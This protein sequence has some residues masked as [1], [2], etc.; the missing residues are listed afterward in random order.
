M[1]PCVMEP[2]NTPKRAA[3]P[4]LSENRP[5]AHFSWGFSLP[6][7]AGRLILSSRTLRRWSALAIAISVVLLA[8]LVV[9][10]ILGTG[11]IV[12]LIWP[13]PDDWWLLLW[14]PLAALVFSLLFVAGGSTIPT[15]ATAPILDR[16]S[17]ETER[18]LGF[19]LPA[20]AG[21]AKL[22]RETVGASLKAGMRV[23]ILL[24]G[25]ALLLLL[26]L[27]PGAGP[28]IWTVGS[29]IWTIFWIAYEYVDIAANRH[30][31]RFME[32]VRAVRGH[33]FASVGLGSALYLM[34]LVPLLNVV[35]IPV[36]AVSATCF[37][38]ELR[39]SGGLPASRREEAFRA[40]VS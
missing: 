15:I 38:V 21:L 20:E 6:L 7:R 23:A 22:V 27:I 8:A 12:A 10:L 11:S 2:M 9:L 14:F 35:F 32:V 5:L 30:D 1:R 39:R 29:A 24:A 18:L 16:L 33:A 34:L 37:F 40:M 19:A 28:T 13:K 31:Y 25:Y 17:E 4:F 26:W 36:G 3:G